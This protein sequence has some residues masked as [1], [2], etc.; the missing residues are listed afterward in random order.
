MEESVNQIVETFKD[1][2]EGEAYLKEH[3]ED[4]CPQAMN[5][6]VLT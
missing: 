6:F 3:Q 1:S 5:L 2:A 4:Y